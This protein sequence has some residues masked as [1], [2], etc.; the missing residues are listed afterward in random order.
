MGRFALP[1][2][3]APAFPAGMRERDA[4]LIAALYVVL[5]LAGVG[6]VGVGY[7]EARRDALRPREEAPVQAK[8]EAA[9]PVPERYVAP[10]PITYP[11]Y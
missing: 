11:I 2:L 3:P 1:Q 6:Y 7:L 10:L 5:A 8:R 4:L 9:A